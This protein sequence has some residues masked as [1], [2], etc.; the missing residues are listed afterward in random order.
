MYFI[1]T[2]KAEV[3]TIKAETN[4]KKNGPT[5]FILTIFL[6]TLAVLG[7]SIA[8]AFVTGCFTAQG[9]KSIQ[10]ECNIHREIC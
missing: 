2:K 8:L 6:L 4:E 10:I 5:F 3:K 9:L 1:S 7:L